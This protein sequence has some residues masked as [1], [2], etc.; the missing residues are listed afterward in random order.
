M[1]LL[2]LTQPQ[3]SPITFSRVY[4]IPSTLVFPI[5]FLAF[6]LYR[7]RS[8]LRRILA[9]RSLFSVCCAIQ[10]LRLHRRPASTFAVLRKLH[11]YTQVIQIQS[12]TDLNVVLGLA[13]SHSLAHC[14]YIPVDVSIRVVKYSTWNLVETRVTLCIIQYGDSVLHENNSRVVSKGLHWELVPHRCSCTV[15]AQWKV[16]EQQTVMCR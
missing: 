10:Q 3:R 11:T 16:W 1:L 15:Q 5:R 8:T 13:L 12:V 7:W 14:L 6:I 2:L 4:Q 9:D